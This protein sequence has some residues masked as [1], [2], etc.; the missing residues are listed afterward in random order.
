MTVRR[1]KLLIGSSSFAGI[2]LRGAYYVDKTKHLRAIL[3]DG[4]LAKLI[5]RPRRFGKSLMMSTLQSFLETDYENP[6]SSER[7]ERLFSG[8]DVMKDRGFCQANMGKWPVIALSFKDVDGS[9]FA[10]ALNQLARANQQCRA[11]S[12]VP[13]GL[14]AASA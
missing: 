6:S 12:P 10:Q 4:S 11:S 5:T 7:Q 14:G 1:N 8:I 13:A 9:T 3:D 2:R